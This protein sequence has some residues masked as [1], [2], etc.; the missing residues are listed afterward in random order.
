[1][2]NRMIIVLRDFMGLSYEQISETLD[3]PVG[4]VKSRISRARS[5]LRELLCKDKEHLFTDYVK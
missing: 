2:K 4:T 3:T 5:E 1:M